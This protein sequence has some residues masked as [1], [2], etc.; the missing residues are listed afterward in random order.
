MH[1]SYV[2][3]FLEISLNPSACLKEKFRW[4]SLDIPNVTVVILKECGRKSEALA[5]M[6]VSVGWLSF[7][8][9]FL[10][11]YIKF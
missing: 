8:T 4:C 3:K 10:T 9:V 11:N 5:N 7:I 6:F 2:L 1:N